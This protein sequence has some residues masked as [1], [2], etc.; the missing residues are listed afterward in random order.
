MGS[1]GPADTCLCTRED[2]GLPWLDNQAEACVRDCANLIPG[3]S[4]RPGSD[5]I[6]ECPTNQIFDGSGLPGSGPTGIKCVPDCQNILSGSTL[7]PADTCACTRVIAGLQFIDNEA[8]SCV[9]DC[10]TEFPGASLRPSSLDACDC[11]PNQI[12]DFAGLPGSGPGGARCVL[13]C[14][15]LLTGSTLNGDGETCTCPVGEIDGE[16]GACVPD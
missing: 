5:F 13:D 4:L 11:P 14:A 8:G 6:C 10:A 9:R 16:A 7:G 3:S 15:N 1:L 2:S 12:F